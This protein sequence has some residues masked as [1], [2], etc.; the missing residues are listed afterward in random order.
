MLNLDQAMKNP[1]RYFGQP[2]A[3]CDSTELSR[4]QKR[5]VLLQWKNQLQLEQTADNESMQGE[6]V[7][8]VGAQT[9]QQVSTALLKLDEH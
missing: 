9:L 5:A 2:M 1:G 6:G 7:P 3:V 4:E 8:D